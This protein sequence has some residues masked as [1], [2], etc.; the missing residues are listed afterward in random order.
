MIFYSLQIYLFPCYYLTL[1]VP[2]LLLLPF[3][4]DKIFC[5]TGIF[6]YL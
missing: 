5:L 4:I 6:F 3:N 1:V 2:L